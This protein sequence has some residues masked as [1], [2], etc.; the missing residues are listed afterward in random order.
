M[1]RVGQNHTRKYKPRDSKIRRKTVPRAHEKL[2]QALGFRL[3]LEK[4]WHRIAYEFTL[5]SAE[6][7][8]ENT[9]QSDFGWRQLGQFEREELALQTGIAW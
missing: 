9:I 7:E 3:L 5:S 8:R 6:W 1:W 2:T 4:Q